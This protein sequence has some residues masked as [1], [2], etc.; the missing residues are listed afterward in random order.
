MLNTELSHFA[1][2]LSLILSQ[3]FPRW[4]TI[5]G[6]VVALGEE[7]DGFGCAQR[8]AQQSLPVGVLPKM[9]EDVGVGGLQRR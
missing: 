6:L 3:L 9:P 7:L 5:D 2:S 1:N 8:G 4:L